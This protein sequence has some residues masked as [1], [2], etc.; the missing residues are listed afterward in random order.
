MCSDLSIQ[1]EHPATH[2]FVLLLTILFTNQIT[3]SLTAFGKINHFSNEAKVLTS[4]TYCINPIP[5]NTLYLLI[6]LHLSN[7]VSGE[8]DGVRI[9]V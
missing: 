9:R 4:F 3:H 8:C 7:N 5:T 1:I 2:A 6:L